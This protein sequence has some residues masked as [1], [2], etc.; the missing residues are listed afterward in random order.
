MPHA[1]LAVLHVWTHIQTSLTTVF[2]WGNHRARNPELR[3]QTNLAHT[4]A[5]LFLAMT[6]L[7]KLKRH[8]PTLDGELMLTS[9]HLHDV[10]EAERGVDTPYINKKQAIDVV[11]FV[12]FRERMQHLEPGIRQHLERAFLLQFCLGEYDL[13]PEDVHEIMAELREDYAPEAL[14]FAALERLDYIKFAY[15]SYTIHGDAIILTHVLRK[16]CHEMARYTESI[17]GFNEVWTPE[18]NEWAQ[19]FLIDHLDVPEEKRSA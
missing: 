14:L 6:V 7:P 2:R 5:F 18:M 17:P 3:Q 9:I 4:Y 1:F 12:A 15:E 8:N 16:Q 10:G 13:F 11:E 19:R